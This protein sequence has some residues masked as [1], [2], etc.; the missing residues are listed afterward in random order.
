MIGKVKNC[1]S[2]V[3][4]ELSKVSWT[5]RQELIEAAW[6]VIATSAILGVFIFFCDVILS[7]GLKWIIR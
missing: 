6:V 1:V 5:S 7:E 2:E 3:V 4:V